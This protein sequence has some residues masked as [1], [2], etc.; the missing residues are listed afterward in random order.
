MDR[1]DEALRMLKSISHINQIVNGLQED[2]ERICTYLTSMT[3]KPKDVDVQT[4]L[5]ADPMADNVI[6]MVEYEKELEEYQQTLIEKK[7]EALR[8]IKQMD[9]KDQQYIVLKYFNNKTID[10][11]G[12]IVG[13]AYRQT[14]ENI[15]IAEQHFAELY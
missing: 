14:W 13:Y 11:I 2:I 8:V 4:N 12:E 3:I 15:H 7:N 9:I 10:Q 1:Q 5:P 6:K